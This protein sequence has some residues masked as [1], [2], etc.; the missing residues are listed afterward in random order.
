MPHLLGC[1]GETL[2]YT[3]E[4]GSEGRLQPQR[5]GRRGAR[6]K[7]VRSPAPGITAMP[8]VTGNGQRDWGHGCPSWSQVREKSSACPGGAA[9]KVGAE[10]STL[11]AQARGLH[12]CPHR[13]LQ[14]EGIW[15]SAL[16]TLRPDHSLSV[17][18]SI[19]RVVNSTPVL[20]PLG[21]SGTPTPSHDN[22][23]QK[24]LQS[25]PYAP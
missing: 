23:N 17:V 9:M 18:R 22:P 5:E 13:S 10:L 12:P 6:I 19:H 8:P 2:E 15:S 7:W 24:C 4:G 11:S 1:A 20:Y 25:L 3:A 14:T 16:L 21:A